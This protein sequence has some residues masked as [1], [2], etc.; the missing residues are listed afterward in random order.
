MILLQNATVGAGQAQERKFNE[1]NHK[2]YH[3]SFISDIGTKT[4]LKAVEGCSRKMKESTF[5]NSEGQR[6]AAHRTK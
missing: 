6:K 2:S 4:F 3:L 1:R 5:N